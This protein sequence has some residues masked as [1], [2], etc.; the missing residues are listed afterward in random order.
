L[1]ISAE[2]HEMNSIEIGRMIQQPNGY[3]AF[4]PNRFPPD[5]EIMLS[6]EMMKKHTEAIRL[7][8]K[9][10]GVVKLLPDM[11]CF[12]LMFVRKDA[13]SSSQ[14][15]GTRATMMDVIERQNAE[16]GA[17]IPDDVDDIIHYIDSLNYGINRIAEFPFSL[18]FIRELHENLM[19]SARSTQLAYPGEFRTS[20]NWIG[21]TRPDNARFVPPPADEM[22]RALGDLEQF[23]YADDGT[24]PLVKAGLL[25]AQFETIHPFND[26]NGRTGRMLI[27][28]YLWH[29]RLI[30]LPVLY[31]SD[32]FKSYREAYFERIDGYHHGHVF[33]WLDFFLE[34]II[35]TAESAIDT[36]MAI[37]ELRERDMRKIHA[38]GKTSAAST[39]A[40]LME[41][42]GLP[43]VGIADI[44]KW[45]GFTNAGGYKA[46]ERL[47][48]LG[49]LE[50]IKEG[51][52]VYGQKWIYRD[53]FSLFDT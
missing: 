21:G 11:D 17:G 5:R 28:M 32:Y 16:P 33:E 8:G 23:F 20:Q 30:E 29:E 38:L 48:D 10:D 46:I 24:L 22:M 34:G 47:V 15:E 18:R 2:G 50:P 36:C 31:L 35:A 25:H 43:I 12:L 39:L 13:S 45:T 1:K 7:L 14:I 37:I 51:S 3:K 19:T 9:L 6:K 44:V 4:V 40:I 49:I 26:G 53:Y 52:S 27:T 41:L 42:F